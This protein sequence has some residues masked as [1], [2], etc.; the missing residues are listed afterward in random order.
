[1]T[2]LKKENPAELFEKQD[3][4][5]GEDG[6]S[7]QEGRVSFQGS[8]LKGDGSPVKGDGKGT[9]KDIGDDDAKDEVDVSGV[10]NPAYIHQ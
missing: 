5:I 10:D 1:M 3:S 9:S 7:L 6:E 8:P 2:S 4:G